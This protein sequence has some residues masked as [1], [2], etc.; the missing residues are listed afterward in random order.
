MNRKIILALMLTI[1]VAFPTKIIPYVFEHQDFGNEELPIFLY[2]LG[3]DCEA[4]TIRQET[5]NEDM[6]PVEGVNSYLLYHDFSTPLISSG[7]TDADGIIIHELPSGVDHY[8]GLFVL[9]LEKNGYR[10]KEIHFTITQCMDVREPPPEEE[11]PEPETPAEEPE[12]VPEEPEEVPPPP[13]EGPE[14]VPEE[15]VVNDSG[16]PEENESGETAPGES[17]GA[18]ALPAAFIL[19]I[20]AFALRI[21]N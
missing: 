11:A 15:P 8:T 13:V 9:T 12:V 14:V 10:K 5:F 1:S 16:E 6:E 19:S 7:D 2:G 18:C 20:S 21:R 4:A 3:A 17:A